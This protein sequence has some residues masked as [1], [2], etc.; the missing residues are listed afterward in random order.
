MNHPFQFRYFVSACFALLAAGAGTVVWA[1]SAQE[2]FEEG[3]Y[4]YNQINYSGALSKFR[5]AADMGF[6]PAQ[7]KLGTLLDASEFDEEARAWFSKAAEQGEV[8]GQMGLAR[9]LALGEGGEAEPARAVEL[10]TAA[11]DNGSLEAMRILYTAYRDGDMGLEPDPQA[12]E[13]WLKRGAEAGD[14]W[15]QD[16][17]E[18]GTAAEG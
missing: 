14:R 11:A 10:Y 3:M 9:M 12:A 15:S 4:E 18:S 1:Q 2:L 17:L 6:A 13:R 16:I 7:A 5:E 8:E